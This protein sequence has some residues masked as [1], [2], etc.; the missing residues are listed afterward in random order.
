MKRCSH[1]GILKAV[2]AAAAMGATAAL[3][4]LFF[5][6]H[7]GDLLAPVDAQ[8]SAIFAQIADAVM[9]P[10]LLL[11]LTLSLLY[12]WG[13]GALWCRRRRKTAVVLGLL[14]WIILFL[15]A[16]YMT[17]VNNI[18]FGDVITSLVGMALKGGLSGL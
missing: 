17:R 18:R 8:F 10:P 3:A 13:A 16:V 1:S 2:G 14:C 11:L 12:V 9:R 15:L 4:A 7:F 5:L 6:R